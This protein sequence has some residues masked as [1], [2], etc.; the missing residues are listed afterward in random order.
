MIGERIAERFP[1]GRWRRGYIRGKVASD[2]AYEAVWEAVRGTSLPLWDGGC[3][4]GLLAFYLRE[5]GYTAPVLGT[6][7]AEDKIEMGTRVAAKHYPSVTLRAESVENPPRDFAGHIALLDVLHYLPHD[8]Q[9]R[10]LHT[11]IAMLPPGG[12]CLIRFTARDRSWRYA[13]TMLEEIAIR[14]IGWIRGGRIC[15]PTVEEVV[16]PIREAGME[17]DV[18][19]LWGRTPFNSYLL[20]ARRS[21]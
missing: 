3:G 18:R 14:G 21:T 13:V 16:A 5:K 6:D 19:S 12:K 17:Y 10:L 15:F 11:I 8:A 20:T 7:L 9:R 4:F 2:P 1:P